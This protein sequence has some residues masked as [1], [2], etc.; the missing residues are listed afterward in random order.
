MLPEW[1]LFGRNGKRFSY[2]AAST[3]PE[4]FCRQP[5]TLGHR[6]QFGPNNVGIN[7]SLA[8]PSAK[9]AVAAGDDV[10]AAD[11]VGVTDDALRNQLRVFDEVRFRLDDTGK[12]CLALWQLDLLE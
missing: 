9:A 4:L 1:P 7:R 2:S 11:E 12:D 8:D 6:R 10:V 3:A 5:S